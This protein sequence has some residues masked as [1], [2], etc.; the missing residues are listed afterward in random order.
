MARMI[1]DAYLS[2]LLITHGTNDKGRHCCPPR[3]HQPPQGSAALRLDNGGQAAILAGLGD[4]LTQ[5]E[6]E[7]VGRGDD[8]DKVSGEARGGLK[9]IGSAGVALEAHLHKPVLFVTV[10]L[11]VQNGNGAGLLAGEGAVEGAL[12]AGGAEVAEGGGNSG[13]GHRCRLR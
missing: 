9:A 2:A 3:A 4:H 7:Q 8:P 5:A 10:G 13:G 12:A 11:D 6:A 1:R